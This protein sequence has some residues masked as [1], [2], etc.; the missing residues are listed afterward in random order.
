MNQGY[1]VNI[2]FSLDPGFTTDGSSVNNVFV[3]T[4][5]S[6]ETN[7]LVTE[8]QGNC[9]TLEDN[10]T[11]DRVHGYGHEFYLNNFFEY[12]QGQA[13]PIVKD[14]MSASYEFWKSIEA[15][16]EVLEVI[17]YGYKLPFI[18]TPPPVV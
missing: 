7:G 13:N 4:S 14:R 11:D 2:L 12:E 3:Q 18:T 9:V 16:P 10:M 5:N 17:E 1:C 6:E 15:N 8:E